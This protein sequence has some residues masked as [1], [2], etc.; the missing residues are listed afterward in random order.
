MHESNPGKMVQNTVNHGP[1][2]KK[3]NNCSVQVWER[4][5]DDNSYENVN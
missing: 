4:S 3:K 1:N 2:I 5:N